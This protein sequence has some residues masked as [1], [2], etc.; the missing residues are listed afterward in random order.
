VRKIAG[1]EIFF[2]VVITAAAGAATAMADPIVT[3]TFY[4]Y[5]VTGKTSQDVRTDLNRH[6]PFDSQGRRFDG[7]TRWYVRWRYIYK[8]VPEGCGIS[9]VSTN[10]DVA[11]TLP[12]LNPDTDASEDLKKSF[13][14]FA[15]KLRLHEE[16]HG[17]HAIEIAKR[18][19]TGIAALP[20]EGTCERLGQ[21]ANDLGYALIK[22]AN[23]Q[24][25]D[26][27]ARTQHGRTEGVI[28]P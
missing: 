15:D 23:Q 21:V 14:N 2:A 8:S 24:D 19:E 5:D 1:V 28:F 20:P 12:R 11:I 9:G 4:Y 7:Y 6:G 18:I 13:A 3:Q 27:D 17:R 26:Y 25:L 16:Q 10:V 22:E